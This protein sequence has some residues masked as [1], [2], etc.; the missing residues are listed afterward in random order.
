MQPLPRACRCTRLTLLGI[1]LLLLLRGVAFASR[2]GIGHRGGSPTSDRYTSYAL[3]VFMILFVL[4]IPVAVYAFLLRVRE[5]ATATPK[6]FKARLYSSA[7]RWGALVL[8]IFVA[9]TLHSRHPHLLQ[10]LNPFRTSGVKA[11]NDK[12]HAHAAVNP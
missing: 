9:F 8:V 1:G 3:T 2:G 10:Q 5:R 12:H 4:M 7:V 11:P 6:T